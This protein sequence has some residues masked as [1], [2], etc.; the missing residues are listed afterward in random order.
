[1][2][3]PMHCCMPTGH[4]QPDW[5]GMAWRGDRMRSRGACQ[6]HCT[7]SLPTYHCP[8]SGVA[9]PAPKWCCLGTGTGMDGGS[10]YHACASCSCNATRVQS[11]GRA[12]RACG[13]GSCLPG[14][15]PGRAYAVQGSG[16]GAQAISTGHGQQL[17]R[18][19]AGVHAQPRLRAR[20]PQ[21]ACWAP[22][23]RAAACQPT[24]ALR[25]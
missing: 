17:A 23:I 13:R 3:K 19:A 11:T 18:C 24:T 22:C 6:A 16:S 20:S 10:T 25:C 9:M 14:H 21:M 5:H 4:T 8:C 2:A 12:R 15:W 7:S 1:M